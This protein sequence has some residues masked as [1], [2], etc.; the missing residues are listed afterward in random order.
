ML[1][2]AAVVVI[3]LSAAMA[4]A[5][6]WAMKTGKSGMID[7]TWSLAVGCACFVAALWP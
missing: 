5:W 1:A 7:A 6:A 2:C 3:F 4:G